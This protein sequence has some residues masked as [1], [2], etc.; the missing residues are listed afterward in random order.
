MK[1][2]V[3]AIVTHNSKD[4]FRTLDQFATFLP[5]PRY[6]IVVYDN[7]SEPDY[8]AHLRH[9]SFIQLIESQENLGF[10]HGHNEV[11]LASEAEI[12]I[13]CNPDICVTEQTLT[14]LVHLLQADAT[15]AAV[16]PK[17]LNED[18][19]TQYLVRQRLTV[20]D[21]FLRFIPF[22][23]LK[24][25]FSKRLAE[26]ECRDL[27]EN[28]YSRIRMGSG[29]FMVIDIAKFKKVNGFDERFFMY[30]EDND[31]CLRFE[32]AGY[33]ILYTPFDTVTHFY[34]KG[35][36][37]SPKLFFVFLQSMRKFFHKWGWEFF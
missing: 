15:L 29:C 27:A 13:I 2:V 21:Y 30:F 28:T 22:Q 26:Y 31:L 19:T 16:S 10:G 17:V 23:S 11:F 34:G 8:L 33:G 5:D 12:G 6:Q 9:Y 14:A 7:H 1:P 25:K 35:A 32:Q 20:F 36:H 37:R 3:I 24:D 4:I 18:G